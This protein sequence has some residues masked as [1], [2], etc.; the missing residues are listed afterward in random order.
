ML[1]VEAIPLITFAPAG[2]QPKVE[3]CESLLTEKTKAIALV[4]PNNPVGAPIS[5]A[6]DSLTVPIDRCY[7]HS[8]APPWVRRTRQVARYHPH[9]RRDIPRF[10]YDRHS[11]SS[12][13]PFARLGLA[14]C[15]RSPVL[16][17]QKLLRPWS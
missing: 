2:F 11:P 6:W 5:V 8:R 17:F 10:H 9:P 3:D 16:V 13:Q 15:R 14:I 1:G 4:S 12:V 7:L